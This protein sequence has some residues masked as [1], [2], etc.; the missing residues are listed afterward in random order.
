MGSEVI[1]DPST[2]GATARMDPIHPPASRLLFPLEG[3]DL[4]ARLLDRKALEEWIPHRG[5]MMLIDSIVWADEGFT[6]GIAVK[7]VREDEFW[8]PG[9]F[10]DRAM[11]PGVL[12]VESAAQL[13]CYLYNKQQGRLTLAAFLRID[14]VAF[15]RSVSPGQDLYLVSEEVKLTKRRFV[16]KVQ[17]FCEGHIT[18]E[19]QITGMA[20][21]GP[22]D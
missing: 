4:S 8:V 21:A 19:A 15:R 14:D 5:Q 1:P 3:I 16:C 7:E 11:L 17:G 6:K 9:H 2:A 10:P 12:M 20:L 22:E 18:F 13:A